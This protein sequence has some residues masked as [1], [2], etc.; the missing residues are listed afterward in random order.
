MAQ[1]EDIRERVRKQDP[2]ALEIF[3]MVDRKVREMGGSPSA[4]VTLTDD[5]SREEQIM[6]IIEGC[7]KDGLSLPE[8][9]Q[10]A[11][12]TLDILDSI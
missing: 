8:A 7:L 1:K 3:D 12:D 11:I 10:K 4:T 5:M 9:E 6:A 2:R